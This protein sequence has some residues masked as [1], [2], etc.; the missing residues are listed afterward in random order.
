MTQL[1]VL[2]VSALA[3]A[4][5]AAAFSPGAG[6]STSTSAL[7]MSNNPYADGMSEREAE[8]WGKIPNSENRGG[9]G[10]G[11]L[12]LSADAARPDK[13]KCHYDMILVERL[14]DRPKTDGGALFVPS[15]E[16]PKF[17]V[18]KVLSVGS[19]R[20][21]ENGSVAPMPDVQVGDVVVAKHPWGIG[22][23]DEETSDG[24]KLSFMRGADIAAVVMGGLAEE[25]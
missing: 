14:Q 13:W 24:K 11:R 18:C 2:L 5:S 9:A 25:E 17:H 3:A 15:D 23:K 16:Q 1:A 20:E 22:P 7:T 6:L 19:G 21:E 8:Y 10:I 4:T 12:T